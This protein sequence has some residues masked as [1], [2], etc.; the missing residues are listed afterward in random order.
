MYLKSL[1]ID[2]QKR[3]NRRELTEKRAWKGFKRI[4][5]VCVDLYISGWAVSNK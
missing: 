3:S 4:E 1:S 2:L 5:I